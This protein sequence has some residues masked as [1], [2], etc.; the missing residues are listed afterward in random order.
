MNNSLWNFFIN[1]RLSGKEFSVA[2]LDI[3]MFECFWFICLRWPIV[4]SSCTGHTEIRDNM[5]RGTPGVVG[6]LRMVGTVV[7]FAST[8][9]SNT[10]NWVVLPSPVQS[11]SKS[12]LPTVEW[13]QLNLH[14]L[15]TMQ[16]S[17]TNRML[18]GYYREVQCSIVDKTLRRQP[19]LFQRTQQYAT[20]PWLQLPVSRQ[21]T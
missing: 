16:C 12:L 5:D 10:A 9:A 17:K 15:R 14:Q 21:L 6:S 11:V 18:S 2:N 3:T 7:A 4:P 13:L 1:G 19:F 8:L 20:G